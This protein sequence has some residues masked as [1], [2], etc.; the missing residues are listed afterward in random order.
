MPV[1]YNQ[2]FLRKKKLQETL[3]EYFFNPT[4]SILMV[5]RREWGK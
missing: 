4:Y 5:M 1:E 3:K 2:S